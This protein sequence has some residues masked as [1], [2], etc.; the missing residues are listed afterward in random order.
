MTQRLVNL[1]QQLSYKLRWISPRHTSSD[2][3][4]R[5]TA[6]LSPRQLSSDYRTITPNDLHFRN[7]WRRATSTAPA[8]SSSSQKRSTSSFPLAGQSALTLCDGLLLKLLRQES[9]SIIFSC[10]SKTT[11]KKQQRNER[12]LLSNVC[13]EAGQKPQLKPQPAIAVSGE[14]SKQKQNRNKK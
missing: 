3:L 4:R 9:G 14:F 13:W 2:S 11:N 10:G 8:G 5:A 12:P 6:R 7:G 1:L